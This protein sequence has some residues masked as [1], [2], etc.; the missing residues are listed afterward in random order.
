MTSD[1]LATS[2]QKNRPVKPPVY[3]AA[4]AD[5]KEEAHDRTE[6]GRQLCWDEAAER[7][8]SGRKW[9]QVL[10]WSNSALGVL[11]ESAGD[12]GPTVRDQLR[13]HDAAR[14]I[15]A[16]AKPHQTMGVTKLPTARSGGIMRRLFRD[17]AEHRKVGDGTTLADST[18]TRSSA[19]ARNS[20]E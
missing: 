10:D 6:Q 2:M 19:P 14:E 1:T 16:K 13:Q 15:G 4:D 8:A 20:T 11:R 7:V 5:V 9:D 18:V 17:V 3:L 12:G